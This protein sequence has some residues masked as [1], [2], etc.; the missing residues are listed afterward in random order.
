MAWLG[1]MDKSGRLGVENAAEGSVG[2]Q[3]GLF[4]D[5]KPEWVE[6]NIN[7]VRVENIKDFGGPWLGLEL[8]RRLEMDRFFGSIC[9]EVKKGLG[10]RKWLRFWFIVDPAIR[11]NNLTFSNCGSWVGLFALSQ[12][13]GQSAH[14]KR[15]SEFQKNPVPPKKT[16]P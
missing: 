16:G 5:V 7:E 10:G 11:I 6:V 9:H 4:E 13:Y 12:S 3:R 14:M 8:M 15:F 2:I 1:E